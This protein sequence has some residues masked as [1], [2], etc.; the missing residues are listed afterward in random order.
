MSNRIREKFLLSRAELDAVTNGL[1]QDDSELLIQNNRDGS[2]IVEGQ[3]DTVLTVRTG[4]H[5]TAIHGKK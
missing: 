3:I 1:D 5:Y 2:D 4:A